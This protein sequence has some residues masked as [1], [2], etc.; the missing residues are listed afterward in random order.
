[1]AAMTSGW[2]PAALSLA[3]DR[4]GGGDSMRSTIP[5]AGFPPVLTHSLQALFCVKHLYHHGMLAAA[6]APVDDRLLPELTGLRALIDG[7]PDV[8]VHVFDGLPAVVAPAAV[9]LVLLRDDRSTGA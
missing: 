4:S 6:P 3:K 9:P 1:M 8:T 2:T 7:L 5:P